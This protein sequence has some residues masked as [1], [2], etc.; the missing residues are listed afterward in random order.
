MLHADH[1]PVNPRQSAGTNQRGAK[2]RRHALASPVEHQPVDATLTARPDYP[3]PIAE[4]QLAEPRAAVSTLRPGSRGFCA[5]S[6]AMSRCPAWITLISQQFHDLKPDDVGRIEIPRQPNSNGAHLGPAPRILRSTARTIADPN[7][8]T[9]PPHLNA[10][11]PAQ[12]GPHDRR[13]EPNHAPTSP[14]RHT[15]CATPP[16]PS[17]TRLG[18]RL[19]LRGSADS[20]QCGPH[21]RRPAPNHAPTSPQRHTSCAAPPARSRTRLDIAYVF[22]APR[23]LCSTAGTIADPAWTSLMS[24]RRRGFCAAQPARSQTRLGH[25]LCLRGAADSVQCGSGCRGAGSCVRCVP[26]GTRV[27][28]LVK[29]GRVEQ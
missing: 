3:R 6:I 17:Q 19:C 14:Q 8:A 7:P 25:R 16:A 23:I 1:S 21:D 10:T 5:K 27:W 13:P 28:W 18:H 12:H 24:S 11:H 26:A 29:R 2:P 9:P 22:A 20:A 15:S 4:T